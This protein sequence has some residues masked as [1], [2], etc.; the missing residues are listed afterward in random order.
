ML[1]S[2]LHLKQF[3]IYVQNTNV[4]TLYLVKRLYLYS[5]TMALYILRH[6]MI[7]MLYYTKIVH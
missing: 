4:E 5:N 3:E 7:L 1:K 2:T 6:K